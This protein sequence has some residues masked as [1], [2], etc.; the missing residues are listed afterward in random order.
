MA[1]G[2]LQT[3]GL[4]AMPALFAFATGAILARESAVSILL[5]ATVLCFSMGALRTGQFLIF[6]VA[7]Q[8][9]VEPIQVAG[10][11]PVF[12]ACWLTALWLIVADH[13]QTG[14]GG[15]GRRSG[16]FSGVMLVALASYPIILLVAAMASSSP[17]SLNTALSYINYLSLLALAGRLAMRDRQFLRL[18]VLAALTFHS[19]L[20][21]SE[22]IRGN[23]SFYG[24]WKYS[25]ATTVAGISRAASTTA[26]PNYL[27]L[28][29]LTLVA[30]LAIAKGDEVWSR[31]E[32]AVTLIS[33]ATLILTFS[34][35]GLIASLVALTVYLV[36]TQGSTN[37]NRR[38]KI[39]LMTLATVA[40]GVVAFVPAFAGLR[41]RFTTF[42]F[43]DASI[44]SRLRIQEL[45]LQ[46]ASQH[47]WTGIGPGNFLQYSQQ[48]ISANRPFDL[49]TD[50]L[51]TYLLAWL[52]G[53]LPLLIAFICLLGASLSWAWKNRPIAACL[54]L[55]IIAALASLDALTFAPLFI[56]LGGLAVRQRGSEPHLTLSSREYVRETLQS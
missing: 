4:V 9:A 44:A 19:L 39:A 38:Q 30:V 41:G 43:A 17:T 52:S 2:M 54:F 13:F 48:L 18:P 26:D 22:V 51:N 24:E 33:V 25:E 20:G 3:R 49:Q 8:G 50:V 1:A 46:Q 6:L 23:A 16:Q 27:A 5:V 10:V 53:G 21:L 29:I 35:A 56:L 42:G 11:N 14:T 12:V 31:T 37:P 7:I 36:K 40:L 47:I 55:G 34:R 32:R 45:A 15:H 28:T